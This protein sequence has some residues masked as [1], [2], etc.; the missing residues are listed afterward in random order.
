MGPNRPQVVEGLVRREA[1]D[2]EGAVGQAKVVRVV[3][4]RGRVQ[5]G[6]Q[7]VHECRDGSPRP[8]RVSPC[9]LPG[10]PGLGRVLHDEGPLEWG[11]F[12]QSLCDLNS[13][14]H[15]DERRAVTL[16]VKRNQS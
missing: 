12:D 6:G 14:R 11:V 8:A 2:G 3:R 13:C 5:V 9:R 16:R 4:R 15:C 1:V 10:L 7:R